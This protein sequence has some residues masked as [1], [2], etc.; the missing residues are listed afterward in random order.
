VET[1]ASRIAKIATATVEQAA[2]AEEVARAIHGI[3]EVTEQ[4]AA[5]SEEMASSSEELGA[6][7]TTLRDLVRRFKVQSNR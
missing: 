5:G 2:N 3:A 4:T 1:T 7:S 6:Q